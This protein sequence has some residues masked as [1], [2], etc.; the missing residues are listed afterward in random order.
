MYSLTPKLCAINSEEYKI[1]KSET[2]AKQSYQVEPAQNTGIWHRNK[3]GALAEPSK[4]CKS[5]SSD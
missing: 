5:L 1:W 2:L 4:D 3:V